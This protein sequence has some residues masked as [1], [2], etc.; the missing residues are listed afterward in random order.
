MKA[1][2]WMDKTVGG[3]VFKAVAVAACV[4]VV[5]AMGNSFTS[6]PDNVQ[7]GVEAYDK[8]GELESS[9]DSLTISQRSITIRQMLIEKDVST[10]KEDVSDT[11]HMVEKLLDIELNRKK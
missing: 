11:R 8:A 2:E 9:V 5:L 3:G 6:I 7:K 10:I 1:R 4:A